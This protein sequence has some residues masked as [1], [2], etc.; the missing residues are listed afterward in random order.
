[1]ARQG[2]PRATEPLPPA[3][4]PET[5]TVG[6][7]VAETVRFYRYHF[8]QSLPLGLSVAA[9]TQLSVALGERR[10]E[11][12]VFRP[13]GSGDGLELIL[14]PVR[15]TEKTDPLAGGGVLTTALLGSLLLTLSYLAACVL[16]S[17]V[18]P[19]ARRALTA[20][21]AGVLAFLPVPFLLALFVLPAVAW[22][23]F[24]GLVVPVAVIEGSGLRA[25]FGR[26]VRLARA[27]FV[28]AVGG[29]ATLV[30]AWFVTRLA[31]L[32]LLQSAGESTARVAAFIADLVLSPILFVGGALLYYDQAARMAVRSGRLS[33]EGRRHADVRDADDADRPGRADAEGEP[34]PAAGGQP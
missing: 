13:I 18:R 25:S 5:R 28:H 8:W 32:F 17:R 20:Y 9:L 22:L 4:P 14:K 27:D 7:L 15:L 12:V 19:D 2:R 6:Q 10:R 16:V 29:L 34:R 23:G 31:L 11:R 33:R 26:A 3:L 1:M 24:V 30:I 21:A